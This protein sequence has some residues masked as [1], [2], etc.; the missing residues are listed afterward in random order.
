MPRKI[1]SEKIRILDIGYPPMLNTI[2]NVPFFNLSPKFVMRS[3]GGGILTRN[4][5]N[6][7][8]MIMEFL[9]HESLA[10]RFSEYEF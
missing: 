6:N 7:L 8:D 10:V 9:Y 5:K 4:T 1:I 2:T 3:R